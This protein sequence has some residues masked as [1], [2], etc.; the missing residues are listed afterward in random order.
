MAREITMTFPGPPPPLSGN[1]E[2]NTRIIKKAILQMSGE[3]AKVLNNTPTQ[4]RDNYIHPEVFRKWQSELA[5]G[6]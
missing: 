4:A 3:V 1:E 6:S 2:K 5:T